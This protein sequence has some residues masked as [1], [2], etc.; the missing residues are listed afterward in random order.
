[1]NAFADKGEAK[2]GDLPECCQQ[3]WTLRAKGVQAA[4]GIFVFKKDPVASLSLS[5]RGK[6]AGFWFLI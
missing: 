5:R 3:F 6:V 1:V 4:V 2:P